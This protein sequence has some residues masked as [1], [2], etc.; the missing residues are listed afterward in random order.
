MSLRIRGPASCFLKISG[1]SGQMVGRLL[2]STSPS[3]FQKYICKVPTGLTSSASV[4]P[5]QS[6]ETKP[7][8]AGPSRPAMQ[9]VSEEA[10]VVKKVGLLIA[11]RHKRESDAY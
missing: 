4:V 10:M 2:V 1:V 7:G 5:D 9:V 6:R 11:N 3:H 8:G